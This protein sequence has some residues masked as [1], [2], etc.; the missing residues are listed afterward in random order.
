MTQLGL[1]IMRNLRCHNHQSIPLKNIITRLPLI[2]TLRR[3]IIIR[4]SIITR[5]VSTRMLSITRLQLTSTAKKLTSIQRQRTPTL[6]NKPW[7]V[8]AR[9]GLTFLLDQTRASAP[10]ASASRCRNVYSL[11]RLF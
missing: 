8:W 3:I 2:T 7:P 4:P 9:R 1:T 11:C 10:L 5:A 6:T